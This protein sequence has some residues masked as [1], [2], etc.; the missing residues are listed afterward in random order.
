MYTDFLDT[1]LGVIKIQATRHEIVKVVFNSKKEHLLSSS[2]TLKCKKQLIEYFL[3][4]RM[5][6]SLPLATQGTIFQNLIWDEIQNINFGLCVTYKDIACSIN[7]PRAARA[8]G[9]A[10]NK[11]PINII[12]PCHRVIREDGRSIHYAGGIKN[13]LWLIDYEASIRNILD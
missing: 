8:V 7:N 12:I 5:K 2:L 10:L 3:G 13:K 9:N 4:K 11:N 1:P 6:F